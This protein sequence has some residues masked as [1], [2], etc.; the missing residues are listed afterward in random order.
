MSKWNGPK[1][2]KEGWLIQQAYEGMLRAVEEDRIKALHSQ[3]VINTH[4]A[5]LGIK[6]GSAGVALCQRV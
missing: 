1:P 2:S 6:G 3:S 4:P 5:W